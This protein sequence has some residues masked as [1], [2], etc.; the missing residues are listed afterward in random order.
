MKIFL[1][2][3]ATPD[4]SRKDI[5][6]DIVP[7]PALI[8]KGEAEARALG[9]FLKCEGL[10]KLYY[11]PF[12][13]AVQTAK[14]VAA[15]NEIPFIEENGLSE[16]RSVAEHEA[17]VRTR[18]SSIFERAARESMELGPI[19]LISHGGPIAVLLLELGFP[20]NEL[21]PYR[22]MFDTT[23]PL[24]PAGAWKIEKVDG[25]DDWKFELVFVPKV[26]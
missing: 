15:V 12:E 16:W 26:D 4:W 1:I 2:R 9:N 18:M 17:Q 19:G 14:I 6:Y 23:N 8:V 20:R 11:S 5:P 13:R 21:M 25:E 24:P 22:S 10:K 7:G 3:H